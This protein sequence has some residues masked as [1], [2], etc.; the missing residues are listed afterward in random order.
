MNIAIGNGF[1]TIDSASPTTDPILR[2]HDMSYRP[3]DLLADGTAAD[4]VANAYAIDADHGRHF[5][6]LEY[7]L[8]ARFSGMPSANLCSGE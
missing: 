4:W 7:N 3:V 2:L 6:K 8:I 1:L 5:T